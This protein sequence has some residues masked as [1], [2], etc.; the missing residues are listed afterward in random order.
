MK[1]SLIS[2]LVLLF[3]VS[4]L[5]AEI[6][7]SGYIIPK[8]ESEFDVNYYL[9]K[10]FEVLEPY[11]NGDLHVTQNFKYSLNGITFEIIYSAFAESGTEENRRLKFSGFSY[12]CA[13]NGTGLDIS[14]DALFAYNDSDV[15]AEFNGD[16]GLGLFVENPASEFSKGYPYM[17]MDFYAKGGQGM[18]VRT[19]LFNDLHFVM[20]DDGTMNPDSYWMKSYHLFKFKD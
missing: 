6:L 12:L 17:L 20:N 14:P 18:I 15:R 10:G 2:V 8:D 3:V 11:E 19:F 7:S 1:K 9:P 13:L 5:S 4:S 16:Y